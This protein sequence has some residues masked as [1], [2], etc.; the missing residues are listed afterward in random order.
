MSA[1]FFERVCMD[2]VTGSLK[3]T[4]QARIEFSHWTKQITQLADPLRLFH[5]KKGRKEPNCDER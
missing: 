4:N 1:D 2:G 5:A 3:Y